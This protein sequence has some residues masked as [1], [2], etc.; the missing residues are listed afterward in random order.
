MQIKKYYEIPVKGKVAGAP[1]WSSIIVLKRTLDLS[2][3]YTRFLFFSRNIDVLFRA[4][5]L[6][7]CILFTSVFTIRHYIH[8]EIF[9]IYINFLLFLI[10]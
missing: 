10:L 6:A 9:I 1:S 8:P 5:D 2:V 3:I 7:C 4:P